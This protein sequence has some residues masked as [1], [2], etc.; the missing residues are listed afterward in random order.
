MGELALWIKVPAAKPNDPSSIPGTHAV[1]RKNQI[2]QII[3]SS[4]HTYYDMDIPVSP[5]PKNPIKKCYN[6]KEQS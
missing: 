5:P 2:P 6:K 3:L 1:E 4:P